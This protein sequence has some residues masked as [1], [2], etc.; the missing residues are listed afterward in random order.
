MR[1]ASLLLLVSCLVTDSTISAQTATVTEFPLPQESSVLPYGMTTRPD[2]N[3]CFTAPEGSPP[4]GHHVGRISPDG[5]IVL[6]AASQGNGPDQITAGPD[7]NLWFT[8]ISL[9]RIVRITSAGVMTEFQILTPFSRPIGITAGPDGAVWFTELVASKI[10]R[11]TTDGTITEFPLPTAASS[12]HGITTGPDG[13]LWFTEAR[14]N[15]IGRITTAG[16]INE[17]SIPTPSAKPMNIT[18][19]SDLIAG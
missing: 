17:F 18:V 16:L 11:I 13:A 2:A 19:G 14:G 1:R 12:P 8:D 15:K 10:G 9:D 5:V 6:F 4:I 7:G 3:V